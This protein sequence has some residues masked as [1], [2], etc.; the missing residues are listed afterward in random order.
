MQVAITHRRRAR[1][2][3]LVLWAGC[4][5]PT[6]DTWSYSQRTGFAWSGHELLCER[7]GVYHR[8]HHLLG[9][10]RQPETALWQAGRRSLRQ[11][12]G[13]P[14]FHPKRHFLELSDILSSLAHGDL[15]AQAT[16]FRPFQDV[17]VL[18]NNPED[19]SSVR[20]RQ[21]QGH[22]PR[23]AKYFLSRLSIQTEEQTR[24]HSLQQPVV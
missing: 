4:W 19:L 14:G 9:T 3:L 11:T 17:N 24:F 18:I 6:R 5:D 7:P 16:E 1:K 22:I 10:A 12:H 2:A 8:A 20:G 15:G 13:F 23:K 21:F